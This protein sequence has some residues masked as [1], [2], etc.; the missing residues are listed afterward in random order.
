MKKLLILIPLTII[1]CLSDLPTVPDFNFVLDSINVRSVPLED[2]VKLI[3]NG[4]YQVQDGKDLLGDEIVGK[5]ISDRWCLYSIHDVV[6]SEN[7][8]SSI[9]DS[10]PTFVGY[11]RIVR[12]GSGTKI[13]L[14]ILP[15]D[16]GIELL[17]GN[18][19][20]SIIFNGTT[21]SG[22]KIKFSR[23]RNLYQQNDT[24]KRFQII[25]HRG[26][27]RNAERLGVSENSIEMIKYS[28]ILGATGVEIDV[29][30]TRDGKIILFHDDT[31]SPRTVKG[32]YLLGKVENFDIDQIHAF[33][34][35]YYGEVIPTLEDALRII[36][37]ETTISLVWIDVK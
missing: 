31:F 13:N 37:E 22:N 3:M 15:S 27:G 29:K 5:W 6:Y 32:T 18:T 7:K 36:I 24:T 33:G 11:I 14:K 20:A 34:R 21:S 26:G 23:I 9:E 25:G 35:L 12:S 10:T 28:E 4:I 17:S 16:G 30:K 2:S 8:C 1:S 19:P